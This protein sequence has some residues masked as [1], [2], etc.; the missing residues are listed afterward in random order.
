MVFEIL[1]LKFFVQDDVNKIILKFLGFPKKKEAEELERLIGLA[2]AGG[3]NLVNCFRLGRE[4]E[5]YIHYLLK[6]KFEIFKHWMVKHRK[7][8]KTGKHLPEKATDHIRKIFNKEFNKDTTEET[9]IRLKEKIERQPVHIQYE[10]L[11]RTLSLSKVKKY[12]YKG[13]VPE[14][15]K[16]EVMDYVKF[17]GCWNGVLI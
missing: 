9:R 1:G 13:S 5:Y 10:I 2:V 12:L 4:P 3:F 16:E 7:S 14:K 6:F 11:S 15:V 8:K 17:R